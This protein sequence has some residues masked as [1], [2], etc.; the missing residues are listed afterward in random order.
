LEHDILVVKKLIWYKEN[1]ILQKKKNQ[2][3][4]YLDVIISSLLDEFLG[5]FESG[6][7]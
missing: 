4:E 6:E 5:S 2:M 7:F 1:E 3:L